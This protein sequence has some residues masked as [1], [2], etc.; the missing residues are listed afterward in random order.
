MKGIEVKNIIEAI[1]FVSN[2]PISKAQ[3]MEVLGA[4]DKKDLEL[5][6]KDLNQEYTE[7]NHSFRIEE[8]AGGWQLRTRAEFSSWIKRMLNIQHRE[9]LSGPALETLAIIA[10]KQPITKAEIEGIRG[11]SADYILHSLIDR[12]LI[13]I[14][15]RKNIIGRPFLYGTSKEFLGHFGLAGLKDLP[16]IDVLKLKENNIKQQ[17]H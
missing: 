7:A 2:N 17:V 6:I 16:D 8:I 10:Y 12:K 14:T 9:H 4:T 11:V 1:L 5:A 15:G 3:M 13:R